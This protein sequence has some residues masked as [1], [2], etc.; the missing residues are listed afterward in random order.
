MRQK[1]LFVWLCGEH[2]YARTYFLP[3]EQIC[4]EYDTQQKFLLVVYTALHYGSAEK[5][6]VHS[7]ILV[8]SH[9]IGNRKLNFTTQITLIVLL[10]LLLILSVI[11]LC[12]A[13]RAQ[14]IL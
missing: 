8:C 11:L 10:S 3:H 12:L 14:N 7:C 2:V 5:N 6:C 13:M 9:I 1:Y 4:V